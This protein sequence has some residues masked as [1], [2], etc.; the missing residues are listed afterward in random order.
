MERRDGSLVG[1]EV[2]AGATIDSRDFKGLAA[3]LAARSKKLVRGVVLYTGSTTV[4]H[5]PG[6]LALPISAL[7]RR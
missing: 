1:I 2:K 5:G 7:W 4:S 6:L 3:L